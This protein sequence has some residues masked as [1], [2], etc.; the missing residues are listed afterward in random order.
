MIYAPTH[1]AVEQAR[2]AFTRKWQLRCK[3]V[4]ASWICQEFRV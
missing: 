4:S 3:A 2:I 1:E